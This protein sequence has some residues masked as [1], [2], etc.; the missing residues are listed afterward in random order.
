[1]GGFNSYNAGRANNTADKKTGINTSEFYD[2]NL[3]ENARE[4]FLI[5]NFTAKKTQPKHEGKGIIFSYYKHIPIFDTPLVEGA[6]QGSG[7]ALEKVNIRATM[8][9]YGEFVPFTDDLDIYSED[10]AQFKKTT[11]A[12]LGGTAGQTQ[13]SL[14]F[15]AG[16]AANTAIA[17]NTDITTTLDD[18][19]ESL[20][21]A[22]GSKFTSMITGSTKYSTE[23]IDPAFVGFVTVQGARLM[24]K[25][26]N[27]IPVRKYGYSDGL[28]PN[29][30][31]SHEGIRICETTIRSQ[32]SGK[33]RMLLLA[34]EALAEVS[35]RGMKKIQTI[36]KEL[37][38]AGTADALNTKGAIG[39]KFRMATCVLR[40]DWICEVSLQA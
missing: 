6:A 9:T 4:K 40:P 15:D 27:F 5:S 21:M 34:E 22:I 32:K 18:A 3:L 31:G 13:E 29:E 17:F 12:M 23:P 14:L 39:S 16:F 19:E 10:G 8:G 2:R 11:T 7:A 36:I 38:S 25:V 1:M 24:K 33:E 28:L 20:R 35:I 26:P 30:I 37:G